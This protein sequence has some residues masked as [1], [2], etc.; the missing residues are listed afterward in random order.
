[1]QNI[2]TMKKRLT[3]VICILGVIIVALA[4]TLI[5]VLAASSQTL[6]ASFSI[7]YDIGDNIAAKVRISDDYNGTSGYGIYDRNTY[8]MLTDS[9]GYAIFDTTTDSSINP[10]SVSELEYYLSPEK[11]SHLLYFEVENLSGSRALRLDF[12]AS[13]ASGMSVEVYIKGGVHINDD[14]SSADAEGFC[15]FL[16]TAYYTALDVANTSNSSS[17]SCIIRVKV[18]VDN[19]NKQSPIY[20]EYTSS[21]A[22]TIT[23]GTGEI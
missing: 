17:S 13:A 8:E 5:G 18:T 1:M 4:G 14:S 16:S 20:N 2:Q 10:G 11:P 23:D 15:P 3:I 6:G 19:V 12:S 22:L 7:S 9:Q 21:F